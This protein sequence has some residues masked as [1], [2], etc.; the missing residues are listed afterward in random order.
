MRISFNL[1][2]ASLATDI[3]VRSLQYAIE[4]GSL[5]AHYVGTKPVVHADDLDAYVKSLPH[6]RRAA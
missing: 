1:K 2:N 5:T 3:S 4:E 6:A